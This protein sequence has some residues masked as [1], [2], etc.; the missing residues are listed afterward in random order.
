MSAIGIYQQS[1]C[2]A[3]RLFVRYWQMS[4]SLER[5][6]KALNRIRESLKHDP[7]NLELANLYWG[8]LAGPGGDIRSGQRV[9]EA[10]RESA[11]MSTEGAVAF[12]RAYRELG[13]ASGELPR[14]AFFDES[15]VQ[16]LRNGV[17]QASDRDRSA[18]EWVLR[19]IR[20]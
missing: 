14:L 9:V 19:W 16:A 12:A 1:A 10:Y 18:L 11:L 8:A 5:R 7:A 4:G 3:A 20:E 6:N 17:S 2:G 15:L 13:E